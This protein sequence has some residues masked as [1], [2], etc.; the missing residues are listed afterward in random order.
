MK[1]RNTF[2]I[3]FLIMLGFLV[4]AA[5]GFFTAVGIGNA[6][7]VGFES[8]TLLCPLGA[9]LAMIAERTAIPMA[10][11][12]VVFA[13]LVCIILGKIFCSWVCPVHFMS[14]FSEK[15]KSLR[16]KRKA[17]RGTGDAVEDAQAKPVGDV[18]EDAQVKSGGDTIEDA[19][20]KPEK[21]PILKTGCSACA[22]PCGKS[23]GIKIDS[24]HGILAAALGSTLLF[25]FPVFCLICPIGLTFAT[26][27]LVMRLFAFG[28][29][30][31][32]II[33]FP[34]IILAEIILLPKWCQKFCP[35]GALLSLFSGLNRTFRPKVNNEKCIRQSE[36]KECNICVKV[37]PEGINLHDIAAGETT[38]NDC[39]KC[40]ACSDACPR[41]AITFPFLSK[42][43]KEGSAGE[44]GEKSCPSSQNS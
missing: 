10:V 8:I 39:S 5:I 16:R 22:T 20:V 2:R 44:G 24:R 28:A 33:V 1:N 19:Q 3:R 30:T 32:T 36:G 37:C 14:W 6:C 35:L 15:R 34:L 17:L 7:G 26:V 23:K 9:L 27:L 41:G 42:K 18:I 29:T 25:G 4:L 40:R 38:L 12:S 13:L 31:W 43:A 11:I 21:T